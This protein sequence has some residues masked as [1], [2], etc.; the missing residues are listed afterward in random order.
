MI[1]ECHHKI[2][3]LN[4]PFDCL[5]LYFWSDHIFDVRFLIFEPLSLFYKLL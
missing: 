3:I 5:I 2:M 4:K 1:I